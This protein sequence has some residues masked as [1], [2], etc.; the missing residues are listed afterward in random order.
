M[1]NGTCS[2][3]YAQIGFAVSC[4]VTKIARECLRELEESKEIVAEHSLE[5]AKKDRGTS[6]N[7]SYNII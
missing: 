3:L 6:K 4:R 5:E 2:V 7:V 1:Q